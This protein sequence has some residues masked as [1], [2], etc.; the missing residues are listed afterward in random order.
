[1]SVLVYHYQMDITPLTYTL[2]LYILYYN[3]HDDIL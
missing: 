2:P 1:M 3:L